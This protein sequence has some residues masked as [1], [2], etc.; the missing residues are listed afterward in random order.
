MSSVMILS[1][2]AD[3]NRIIYDVLVTHKG[4]VDKKLKLWS[5]RFNSELIID[6]F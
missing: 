5:K 1:D 4:S 3:R 2:K 6:N